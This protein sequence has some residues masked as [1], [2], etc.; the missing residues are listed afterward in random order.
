MVRATNTGVSAFIDPTGRVRRQTGI[1]EKGVLVSDVVLL[2]GRTFFVT[3]GDWLVWTCVLLLGVVVG[4]AVAGR[5]WK[6]RRTS[7]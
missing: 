5:W 7:Q 1:F 4:V 6:K 3:W 2:R